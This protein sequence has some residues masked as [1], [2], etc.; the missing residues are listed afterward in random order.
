M[1]VKVNDPITIAPWLAAMLQSC[2]QFKAQQAALP[3]RAPGDARDPSGADAAGRRLQAAIAQ[4]RT[5]SP[6]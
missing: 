1:E 3:T 2:A 6:R 5:G 4:M